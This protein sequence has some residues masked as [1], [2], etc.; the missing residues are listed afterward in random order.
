MVLVGSVVH[1]TAYHRTCVLEE[2][3]VV[4]S[5][6]MRGLAH[7]KLV[8]RRE[9]LSGKVMPHALQIPWEP[10]NAVGV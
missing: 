1:Q 8:L 6:E 3:E 9:V 7:L 2:F 4:G 5:E 10:R